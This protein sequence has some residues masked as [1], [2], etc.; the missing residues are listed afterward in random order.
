MAGFRRKL[1]E[2]WLGRGHNIEIDVR[3][4]GV[5]TSILLLTDEMIEYGIIAYVVCCTA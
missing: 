4:G 2:P 3:W 5:P 1:Q